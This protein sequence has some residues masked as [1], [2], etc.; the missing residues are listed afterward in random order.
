[1]KECHR[2]LIASIGFY[3]EQSI[4]LESLVQDR[5]RTEGEGEVEGDSEGPEESPLC[6][7]STSLHRE[8]L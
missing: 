3:E 1:M 8:L 2:S 5:E 4:S 6:L 7:M